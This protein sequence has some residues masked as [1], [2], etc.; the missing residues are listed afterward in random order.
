MNDFGPGE[1]GTHFAPHP[2]R[3]AG[4]KLGELIRVKMQPPQPQ[5]ARGVLNSGKQLPTRPGLNMAVGD[6][7]LDLYRHAGQ[8]VGNGRYTGFVF[9]AQR[10]VH[11]EVFWPLETEL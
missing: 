11:D 7:S 10:K 1:S 5:A 4:L 3:I 6:D 8:G 9:V 2:Q